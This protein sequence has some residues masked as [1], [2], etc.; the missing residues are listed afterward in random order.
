VY[1]FNQDFQKYIDVEFLKSTG[2]VPHYFGLG[3]IQLKIDDTL[4]LHFWHP[5][6]TATVPEEEMHDHRYNFTSRVLRGSTTHKIWNFVE[7]ENGDHGLFN[8]SCKPGDSTEPAFLATGRVEPAGSYSM[9]E[10]SVYTFPH[11]QFHQIEATECITLVSRDAVVKELATIVKPIAS[12]HVCPFALKLD[13]DYLWD[14]IAQLCEDRVER[15]TSGYHLT[16]IPKGVLG[17]ASKIEEEVREFMDAVR[18]K[19]DVMALI[20]LADLIGAVEAWLAAKH[21]TFTIDDLKAMAKVTKRAFVSGRR[22]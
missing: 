1:T 14:L 5:A 12:G 7:D 15:P 19:V 20:E 6:L 9:V 8:V 11:D 21:P 3:F 10:G 22:S 4:R 13:K 18:Q 16:D 2:A 17:E